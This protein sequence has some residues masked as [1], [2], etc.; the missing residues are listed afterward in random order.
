MIL[1]NFEVIYVLIIDKLLNLTLEYLRSQAVDIY[2]S[3][4]LKYITKCRDINSSSYPIKD[5]TVNILEFFKIILF[6]SLLEAFKQRE[7]MASMGI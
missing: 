5:I 7:S 3:E 2:H 6:N 4:T 1:T